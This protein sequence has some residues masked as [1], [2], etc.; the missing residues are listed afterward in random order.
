MDALVTQDTKGRKHVSAPCD[1][2]CEIERGMRLIGGKWKGSILWHLRDGPVRFNDLA[3]MISGASKR[4]VAQRLDE[5]RSDGLV[6][7][8]IL[9]EKPRA[10]AYEITPEGRDALAVLDQLRA[11]V[12]ERDEQ[13]SPK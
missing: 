7:Q 8:H 5:L 4:I 11:W 12:Q 9:S 6:D 1:R 10:V 3:R 2:P 13:A